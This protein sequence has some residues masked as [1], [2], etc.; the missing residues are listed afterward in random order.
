MICS[1]AH[2]DK[3]LCTIIT[4]MI[5]HIYSEKK[6]RHCA[7]QPICAF[8][9]K[10]KKVGKTYKAISYF[11]SKQNLYWPIKQKRN[12]NSRSAGYSLS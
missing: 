10:Q 1:L 6:K 5:S 7:Y 11:L 12:H 9:F 4:T 8:L 3:I 2:I